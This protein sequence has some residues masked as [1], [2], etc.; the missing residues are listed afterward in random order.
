MFAKPLIAIRIFG[1][2]YL[3]LFASFLTEVVW[4]SVTAA[5]GL[6]RLFGI[7]QDPP[8]D[9]NNWTFG[10]VASVVLFAGP[11]FVVVQNLT[12][13]CQYILDPQVFRTACSKFSA[14][15]VRLRYTRMYKTRLCF[16]SAEQLILLVVSDKFYNKCHQ[17]FAFRCRGCCPLLHFSQKQ[18]ELFS[19]IIMA[20]WILS[21]IS[22]CFL[23]HSSLNRSQFGMPEDN[24][25][26]RTV[27][28]FGW[29]C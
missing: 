9:E 28:I 7:R 29:V 15:S 2:L 8:A 14:T 22:T 4:L 16:S 20:H 10:R 24:E 5:W 26:L 3:E 19:R 1:R 25:N 13:I 11:L 18:N 21:W 17:Y 12:A 23:G 6:T 27:L